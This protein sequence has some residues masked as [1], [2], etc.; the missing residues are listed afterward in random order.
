MGIRLK[1]LAPLTPNVA[2]L[3]FLTAALAFNWTGAGMAFLPV[4]LEQ[5]VNSS[6]YQRLTPDLFSMQE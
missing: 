1:S 2:A 6:L 5:D 3:A 4:L